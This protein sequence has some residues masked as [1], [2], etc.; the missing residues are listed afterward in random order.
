MAQ[1]DPSLVEK[2]PRGRT[3]RAA[4]ILDRSVRDSNGEVV[5]KAHDMF[6]FRDGPKLGNEPAYRINHVVAGRGAFGDRFGYGRHE[7][8]GPWPLAKLF[9]VLKRR[10]V[11]FTWT[12][13]AE[14]TPNGVTLSKPVGELPNVTDMPE[15]DHSG[16]G[17]GDGAYLGLRL[18][19]SQVLDRSGHMCGSV[20]DLEL[21]LQAGR[22]SPYV[23]AILAGPGALAHRIGGRLGLWIE[24]VH[25]RLHDNPEGPPARIDFD[26]VDRVLHQVELLC[27]CDELETHRFE[28]W[29]AKHLIE[30]IPGSG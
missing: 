1:I 6:A 30:K 21:T 29:T 26:Q 4:A 10:A 12:D 7:M 19:D 8:T 16:R 22:A 15:P 25:K 27:R 11:A 13:I 5:G 18:L 2:G 20:D 24:S 9:E 23:S 3:I 14:I 28:E 17:V